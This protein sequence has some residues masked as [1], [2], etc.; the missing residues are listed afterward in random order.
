MIISVLLDP[1]VITLE[2]MLN[3]NDDA[4]IMDNDINPENVLECVD[5]QDML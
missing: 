4:N 1:S 5:D 2:D 3:G